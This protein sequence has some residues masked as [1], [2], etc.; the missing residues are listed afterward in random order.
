MFFISMSW[1]MPER[2]LPP[3]PYWSDL[4]FFS[5]S[6]SAKRLTLFLTARTATSYF[7]L[8]GQHTHT[9]HNHII[10]QKVDFGVRFLLGGKTWQELNEPLYHHRKTAQSWV[11]CT[12]EADQVLNFVWCLQADYILL[13]V[14]CCYHWKRCK[15]TW[16]CYTR[17]HLIRHQAT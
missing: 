3:C 6:S 8:V 14:L 10:F 11:V 7:L 2:Y 15:F 16:S 4:L 1:V 13:L 17:S 5:I 12:E 9:R